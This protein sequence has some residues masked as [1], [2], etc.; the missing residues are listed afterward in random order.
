MLSSL[1]IIY[2]LDRNRLL[3]ALTA[4]ALLFPLSLI[5]DWSIIAPVFTI[6]FYVLQKKRIEKLS[7]IMIPASFFILRT[8]LYSETQ[9]EYIPG[10]ISVFLASVVVF[11]LRIRAEKQG[12][13]KIIGLV[14]YAYY[15][16]HLSVILLLAKL[17]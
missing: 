1:T 3:I 5:C 16:L 11:A 17:V 13:N 8:I 14:F 15:P 2:L 9:A 7:L 4:L 6:I 10:T 12:K